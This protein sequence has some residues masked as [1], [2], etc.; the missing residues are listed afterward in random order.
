MFPQSSQSTHEAKRCFVRRASFKQSRSEPGCSPR[1]GNRQFKPP[2]AKAKARAPF[3]CPRAA[4]LHRGLRAVL[5]EHRRRRARLRPW[6]SVR[7][8]YSREPWSECK[9]RARISGR[10][11]F[12]QRSS[13]FVGGWAEALEPAVQAKAVNTA[14]WQALWRATRAVPAELPGWRHLPLLAG[15]NQRHSRG[16]PTKH[17][18]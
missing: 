13:S 11:A 2:E 14:K 8:H 5:R 15:R 7:N 16:G 9:C 6:R 17:S 12:R 1:R 18:S 4:T 3:Q 10:R